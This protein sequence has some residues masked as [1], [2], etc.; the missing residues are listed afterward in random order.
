M[1]V[2]SS[3]ILP[4]EEDNVSRILSSISFSC[5]LFAALWTIRACRSSSRSGLLKK[6]N[7]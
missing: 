5:F 6:Q 4:S 1:A 7:F 2:S 3:K